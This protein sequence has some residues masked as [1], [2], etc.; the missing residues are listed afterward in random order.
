M[1]RAAATTAALLS[2]C[3]IA[4]WLGTRH[5]IPTAAEIVE[6][7]GC[8]RAT[9]YR[10]RTFALEGGCGREQRKRS[11]PPATTAV[12]AS[13]RR[14]RSRSVRAG[15]AD[16]VVSVL[17]LCIATE[18]QLSTMLALSPSTTQTAIRLLHAHGV[19]RPIG[20]TEHRVLSRARGGAIRW[21]LAHAASSLPAADGG[22]GV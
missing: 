14:Q 17:S 8:S 15:V 20:H 9:A 21:T 1:K 4:Y 6:H 5:V 18:R 7:T 22:E 16:R 12:L 11:L 3:A 2:P 19:I 13:H 10:W